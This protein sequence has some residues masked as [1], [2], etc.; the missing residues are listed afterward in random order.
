MKSRQKKRSSNPEP[1]NVGVWE[2]KRLPRNSE[3]ASGISADD[4]HGTVA[5]ENKDSRK[6]AWREFVKIERRIQKAFR[7]KR[8]NVKKMLLM[9]LSIA[10]ARIWTCLYANPKCW[11]S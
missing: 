7:L 5:L 9:R 4:N 6:E 8:Y 1:A 11:S 3:I 2:I 10:R